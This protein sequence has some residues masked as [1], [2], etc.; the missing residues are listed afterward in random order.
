MAIETYFEDI[1][2]AIRERGGT[3]ATLTP[4]AMPQAILDIPG[5]GGGDTYYK[6]P[7]YQGLSYCYAASGSLTRTSNK[8]NYISVY[9]AVVNQQFL[10]AKK[11]NLGNR[12]QA[13]FFSGATYEDIIPYI[14]N[15]GSG[16]VISG[17]SNISTINNSNPAGFYYK[18]SSVF[19][20]GIVVIRTST[21]STV[22]KP[23][24]FDLTPDPQ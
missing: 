18:V 2:D 22:S 7:V 12:F 9:P 14:E 4:A 23:Y 1:A 11:D 13:V 3:S 19:S 24:F 20:N 10:I 8:T 15:P 6:N 17:G 21:D 16:T 5:G